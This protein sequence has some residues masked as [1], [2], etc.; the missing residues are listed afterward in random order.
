MRIIDI[1][2]G[3]DGE[4]GKILLQDEIDFG[5]PVWYRKAL[6][7]EN[8]TSKIYVFHCVTSYDQA[9][10]MRDYAHQ[11]D[12]IKLIALPCSGK[13]DM[14]YLA[15]AFET[16]ADGAAIL[17]CKEG[18]CRYLEGNLRAIKRAAAIDT[19]LQEASLGAG[20]IT[21]I[22]LDDGGI[23]EAIRKLAAFRLQLTTMMQ[24][25]S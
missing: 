9:A 6:E 1:L 11:L 13:L 7:L 14:L 12:D 24:H 15:K 5:I 2:T 21:V 23:P 22:Q 3:P 18:E 20:R 10:L 8:R 25:T 17:V 16:G 4:E 19:L